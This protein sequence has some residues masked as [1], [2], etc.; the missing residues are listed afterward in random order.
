MNTREDEAFFMKKL[1]R[2]FASIDWINTYPQYALQNQ[3]ILRLDHGSIILDF[4]VIQP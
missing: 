4:E 3:G 1:D 2:A